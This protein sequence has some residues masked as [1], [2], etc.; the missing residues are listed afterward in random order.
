MIPYIFVM[1]VKNIFQYDDA[2]DT[3]GV[4][5]IV[6]E[7]LERLLTGILANGKVNANLH[8]KP[9]RQRRSC[10]QQRPGRGGR[11]HHTLVFHQFE[12]GLPHPLMPFP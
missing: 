11:V 3:F 1:Y 7:R 8:V 9:F 2:L 6:A 4:H 12:S 5:A 10:E